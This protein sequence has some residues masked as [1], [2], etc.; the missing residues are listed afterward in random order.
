MCDSTLIQVY[1]H[2]ARSQKNDTNSALAVLAMGCINEI[3]CR[4]CVP[5]DFEGFVLQLFKNT[6]YLLQTV[7][8][9]EPGIGGGGGGDL[10]QFKLEN[11]DDTYVD[12]LTDFLRAF[13]SSH[14]RR[15]EGHQQFPVIE[16][17]SL[18]YKFTFR[19]RRTEAFFVCLE[20]WRTC[21]DFVATSVCIAEAARRPAVLQ[22]YHEALASLATQLVD[23]VRL[24]VNRGLLEDLD[25]TRLDDD[26]SFAQE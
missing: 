24:K 23:R 15:F 11:L 14:L 8:S 22:L 10:T 7:V 3:I 25:D 4:N 1:S 13:V 12:K 18:L 20:A 19:Q 17:L 16:F 5:P 2:S 9:Q 21:V 26:V 6:F